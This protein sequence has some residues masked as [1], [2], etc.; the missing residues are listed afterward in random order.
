MLHFRV[1]CFLCCRAVSEYSSLV[2][3]LQAVGLLAKRSE[4]SP[5][6]ALQHPSQH[7]L[8]RRGKTPQSQRS[9][10][11][12]LQEHAGD[13]ANG[14]SAAQHTQESKGNVPKPLPGAP[15]GSQS[16][17]K[18]AFT[19]VMSSGCQLSIVL[20]SAFGACSAVDKDSKTRWSVYNE[21]MASEERF[22][23]QLRIVVD[24]VVRPLQQ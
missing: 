7:Q 3:L 11:Q 6:I 12:G 10:A 15:F 4:D 22:V 20:G 19:T 13:D 16:M 14:M 17:S 1:A 18:Q 9:E 21:L 8:R 24:H 2:A 5:E 23:N